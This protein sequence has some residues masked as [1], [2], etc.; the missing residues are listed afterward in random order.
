MSDKFFRGL[1]FAIPLGLI[2]WALLFGLLL[3]LTGWR[4]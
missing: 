1:F 3:I 4:V 2:G